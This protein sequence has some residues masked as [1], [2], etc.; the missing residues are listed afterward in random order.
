MGYI[1]GD[2]FFNTSGHPVCQHHRALFSLHDS[3]VPPTSS[4]NLTNTDGLTDGH[5]DQ[6]LHF[7][8][9]CMVHI[10][11]KSVQRFFCSPENVTILLWKACLAPVDDSA[12]FQG[13]QIVLGTLYQSGGKYSKWL[14]N[15][16][17]PIK[18][19]P[20]VVNYYVHNYIFHFK[21][22]CTKYAKIGFWS[23]KKPSGNPAVSFAVVWFV[24]HF[25]FV[26]ALISCHWASFEWE[27]EQKNGSKQFLTS[28]DR[29]YIHT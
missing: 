10:A 21:V 3:R 8:L 29:T 17:M 25:S 2:F 7:W 22:L 11:K 1:L 12:Q 13:C 4:E 20:M 19:Y 6:L 26:T 9:L 5:L 18:I 16:Q 15:Y 27:R 28:L 24:W 14:H 23:E